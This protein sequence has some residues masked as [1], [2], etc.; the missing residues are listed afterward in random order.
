MLL[1]RCCLVSPKQKPPL[2]LHVVMHSCPFKA[3]VMLI[4]ETL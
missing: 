4:D 2:T 1:L 3:L